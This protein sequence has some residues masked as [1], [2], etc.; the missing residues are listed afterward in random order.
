M[1][2]FVKQPLNEAARVEALRKIFD[3]LFFK[4]VEREGNIPLFLPYHVT[5]R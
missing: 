1:H 3:L 2:N 5:L 4:R